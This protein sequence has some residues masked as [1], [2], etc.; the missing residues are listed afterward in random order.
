[1]STII[2]CTSDCLLNN[3]FKSIVARGI[4]PPSSRQLSSKQVMENEKKFHA[5]N[6]EPVPIVLSKGQGVDVWDVDGKH[7]LDFLG[8]FASLNQGHCHPRILKAL[9]DQASK[10]HHTSRSHYNDVLW[11]FSEHITKLTGFDKVLEMNTGVEGGETAVKLARLWGYKKKKIPANEAIVLFARGNFWGRTLAA[12]SS[13]VDPWMYE[14]F[15]PYMPNL[16]LVD[17]NNLE[18][19]EKALQNPN[20]CAFMVEPIQG[21]A[22]VVV[23]DKGYLEGGRRLCSA[24]NVLWIDDE[25]QTGLGRTGKMFCH[26]HHDNARPDVMIL[27]KALAGGV[28]P[29][30]AVVADSDVMDCFTPGT[31]GSTFGGN[32]LG[33][34]VAVTAVDVICDEGLVA[35][36]DKMGHIFRNELQRSLPKEKVSLVRGMGLLN[37]IALNTDFCSPWDFCIKLRDNGLVTRPCKANIIRFAPPLIINE[38]QLNQ[39]LE[40]IVKTVNDL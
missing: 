7:Y 3:L 30:S 15:G 24:H 2:K 31:H 11:E 16:N 21:E 4:S 34:K 38:S 35:N 27:G 17:Y 19:L 26:Q 18:D 6:Y 37:A 25:V 20:V 23:P 1:M 5:N 13:S 12:I 8:G 9:M 33:C 28:Y 39:G 32:P 22:G 10:L 40:I 14:N 29:V 36:A